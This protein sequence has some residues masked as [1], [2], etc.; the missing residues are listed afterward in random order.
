MSRRSVTGDARERARDRDSDERVG[1]PAPADGGEPSLRAALASI[2]AEHGIDADAIASAHRASAEIARWTPTLPAGEEDRSGSGKLLLK[3]ESLQLTG[4]YKLR[5]AL[6]KLR[7]LG[8]S[9]RGVVAASAGNHALGLS[10]AARAARIPCAIY[11]P[12]GA[13]LSKVEAIRRLGAEIHQEAQ[14]VD[15]CFALAADAAVSRGFSLVHPFDDPEV[16]AGQGGV[17]IELLHDVP[18]L[19]QLVVPVGGGGLAAGVAIAIKSVR[20]EVRIVGVQARESAPFVE[21]AYAPG[22][23]RAAATVPIADGVAVKRP[24]NITGAIIESLLDDLVMVE[25]HQ[26]AEAMVWLLEHAKLVAEGAGAVAPA[27]ILDGLVSRAPEGST[28]AVVS[29]GNVD[30]RLIAALA[31]W[32]ESR[33]R[34]RVRVSARLSD[35]PGSLATLLQA[36]AGAGANIV[37]LHH[38]REGL[39]LAV[40]EAVVE[41]TVET[42]GGHATDELFSALRALGFEVG[43]GV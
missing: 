30:L 22:G 5:G 12:L 27:A 40:R 38:V 21:A 33:L 19:A 41:L 16:I 37:E 43:E 25:E 36:V 35:Q 24:G 18:D 32:H 4:S 34:S 13:P 17:G 31:R 15:E 9:C 2:E 26:V 42:D 14:T 29:G 3:A 20:P 10:Y 1:R 8:D 11:L 39:P 7:A 23:A 6:N 28:V